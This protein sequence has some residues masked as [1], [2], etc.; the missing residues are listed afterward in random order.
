M[1]AKAFIGEVEV[2][3]LGVEGANP[4]AV[5]LVVLVIGIAKGFEHFRILEGTTA[6]LGRAG[7]FAGENCWNR[8]VLTKGPQG[9]DGDLVAPVVSEIVDVEKPVSGHDKFAELVFS[10]VELV[11]TAIPVVLGSAVASTVDHEHVEVGILPSH[12]CLDHGVQAGERDHSRDDHPTPY[13][14]RD[15]GKSDLD[16]GDFGHRRMNLT[17]LLAVRMP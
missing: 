3:G 4:V 2:E 14:G 5:V 9:L 12:G 1:S 15:V 17:T 6:V 11:I 10:G 13:L 16:F 8:R 7:V